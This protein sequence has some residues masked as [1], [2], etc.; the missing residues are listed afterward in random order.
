[1]AMCMLCDNKPCW[2]HCHSPCLAPHFA[3]ALTDNSQCF[4]SLRAADMTQ[5]ENCWSALPLMTHI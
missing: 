3:V 1:M 5:L 4:I 2:N